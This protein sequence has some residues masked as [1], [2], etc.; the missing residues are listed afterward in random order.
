MHAASAARPIRWDHRVVRSEGPKSLTSNDFRGLNT[1][2][3]TTCYYVHVDNAAE[4]APHARSP[5]R[6]F[7]PTHR[8][9]TQARARARSQSHIG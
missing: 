8:R 6:R 9:R 3:G 4:R 5:L 2:Q 7:T 1:S